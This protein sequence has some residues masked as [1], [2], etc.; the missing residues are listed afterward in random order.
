MIVSSLA[1]ALMSA[2]VKLAAEDVSNAMVVF[3]RN[4][5]AM[6][7]L[8][9]WAAREG[10]RGLA[11]RNLPGHLVRGLAGVSAM[12]C[13]FYAIG[14]LR[15]GDAVVLNQSFPL[16]IPIAE[17][18]WLRE[19]ISSRTWKSL[20]AG[21]VGVILILKPGSGLF[22]EV[23]LVGLLSA[24]LAAVAQVGIRQLTRTDPVARIVFYFAT[25][26]TVVSAAPLP[27]LWQAP[28]PVAWTALFATGLLATIGQLAL[29]RGYAHAPAAQAGPFIYTGVVFAALID[30]VAWQRLPDPLFV[31]GAILIAVAGAAMLRGADRA[32]TGVVSSE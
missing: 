18:V 32:S 22:T 2:A 10:R 17:R 11:T 19:P 20:G 25:I 26:G 24:V 9:P 4:A 8:T 31:P 13:F 14:H 29:T 3:F 28:T 15:L 7:L 1:F 30:W 6:A 23:A 21:F 27:W 16:F 5:V 12:A